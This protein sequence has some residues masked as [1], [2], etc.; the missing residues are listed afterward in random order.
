[1]ESN[2]LAVKPR[3]HSDDIDNEGESSC[4]DINADEKSN[5][6]NP[7]PVNVSSIRSAESLFTAYQCIEDQ[8]D[9]HTIDNNLVA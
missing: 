9:D 4:D 3:A 7:S 8:I 6:Q 5:S 2:S 1:M